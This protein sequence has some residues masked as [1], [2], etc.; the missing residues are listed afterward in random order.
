VSVRKVVF[1]KTQASVRIPERY[2]ESEFAGTLGISWNKAKF[3]SR[4][5]SIFQRPVSGWT[6]RLIMAE[7]DT[8]SDAAERQSQVI[9]RNGKATG[10]ARVG[11][12]KSSPAIISS[13]VWDELF[14]SDEAALTEALNAIEEDGIGSFSEI[15]ATKKG[16]HH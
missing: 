2:V 1:L 16:A 4:T 7:C 14:G 3:R 11:R 13:T 9:L 10:S 5:S 8:P 12:S 15:A 6:L